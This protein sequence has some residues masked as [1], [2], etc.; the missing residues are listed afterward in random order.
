MMEITR[1]NTGGRRFLAAIIDGIVFYPIVFINNWIFEP[2]KSESL[3]V[4]W[5]IFI[6]IISTLYSVLLHYK[7]G[8]TVGKM[9]V[10]IKVVDVSETRNMTFRQSFF[11]D[12]IYILIE[13][14]AVIYIVSISG[15]FSDK[16]ESYNNIVSNA[17][18][19]WILIELITMFTNSKRRALHDYIARSVVIRV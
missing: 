8:Q 17:Q 7:Y 5:T 18:L 4:T 13:L 12:C 15:T 10:R 3:I 14:L 11:R 6:T 2:G 16:L 19:L 1:Y 9:A